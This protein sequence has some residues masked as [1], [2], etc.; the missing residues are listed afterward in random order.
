MLDIET[1]GVASRLL[2]ALIDTLVSVALFFGLAM[3]A[4]FVG[5]NSPSFATTVVVVGLFVI[6][7]V[8]PVIE[9]MWLRGRTLGKAVFGL[10]AVTVDG[11]PIRFREATLRTMGGLVDRLIPP[12][13]ITGLLFVL[14]TERGQTIGDLLAGTVVIRDPE[15]H[16]P[17]AAV[18]FPVP[19]GFEAY[20]ATIDPSAMS[21]EQYTVVRAFLL[22]S[23]TLSDVARA[24]VAIDLADRLAATVRHQR[25][26]FVHPETFLLCAISRFQRR[27]F[28]SYQPAAWTQR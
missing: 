13:G 12:G 24:A 20:A 25:P 21:N 17:T 19:G 8:L 14:G 28:P 1:A 22:R 2:A 16:Q 4:T 9:Q 11:A 18:W 5:V 23:R 26:A 27:N 6:L 3:V 15:R 10:R 7:L